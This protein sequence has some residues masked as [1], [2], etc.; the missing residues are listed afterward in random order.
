[1]K[2]IAESMADYEKS[3][4]KSIDTVFGSCIDHGFTGCSFFHIYEGNGS[5][6]YSENR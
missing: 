5:D 2:N 6:W 1:M 3:D 4:E